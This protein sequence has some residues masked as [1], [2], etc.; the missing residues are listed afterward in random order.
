MDFLSRFGKV[1]IRPQDLNK[2]LDL[3]T[4]SVKRALRAGDGGCFQKI[5]TARCPLDSGVSIVWTQCRDV[6]CIR[7]RL[8]SERYVADGILAFIGADKRVHQLRISSRA[9]HV[10]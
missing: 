8:P 7:N 2:F 10:E 1:G 9:A 6:D 3:M 4:E 5:C